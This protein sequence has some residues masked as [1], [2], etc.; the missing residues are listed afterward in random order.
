M[1]ARGAPRG[2]WAYHKPEL[3][4]ADRII[5]YCASGRRSA[6]AAQRLQAMGIGSVSHIAGGIRAWIEAGGEIEREPPA[7]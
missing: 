5:L 3:L 7:S 4:Q 1:P 6:L 2:R